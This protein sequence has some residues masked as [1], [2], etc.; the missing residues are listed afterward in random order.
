M[1][2]NLPVSLGMPLPRRVGALILICPASDRDR[3]S[4]PTETLTEKSHLDLSCPAL[5]GLAITKPGG[6][7]D[8]S[9]VHLLSENPDTVPVH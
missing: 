1:A 9:P 5:S 7:P 6:D 2:E 3:G 8:I 4:I